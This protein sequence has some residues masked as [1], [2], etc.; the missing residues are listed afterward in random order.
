MHI[1]FI[2][3]DAGLQLLLR[4]SLDFLPIGAV[5]AALAHGCKLFSR[6]AHDIFFLLHVL[7]SSW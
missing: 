4:H 7:P 3:G 6:I 5:F 1:V 2:G